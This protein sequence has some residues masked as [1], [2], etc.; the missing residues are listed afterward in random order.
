MLEIACPWPHKSYSLEFAYGFNMNLGTRR[1]GSEGLD[2]EGTA[3]EAL[4][5]RRQ[6]CVEGE[7]GGQSTPGRQSK[8]VGLIRGCQAGFFFFLMY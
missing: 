6:A 4:K 8:L 5:G 1:K 7:P 2:F 3:R